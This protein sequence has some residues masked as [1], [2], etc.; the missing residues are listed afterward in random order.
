[1]IGAV[2]ADQALLA[3]KIGFLVLLYLFVWVIARSAT[4]DLG[5]APQE[6]IILSAQESEAARS[7]LAPELRVPRGRL[8][9]VR[10]DALPEG[11]VIEVASPTRVGRSADNG[12]RLEDDDFVSG[13]HAVFEPRPG[14]LWLEDAGSTNGSFVNGARVTSARLLQPGDVV[15]IGKTDLEV[16]RGQ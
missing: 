4:R 8:R 11:M 1:M 9:V 15:R 2:S 3:L 6:S 5:T 7:R 12:I 16:E 13:R 10:S 14:G